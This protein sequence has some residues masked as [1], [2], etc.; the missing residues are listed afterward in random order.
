VRPGVTLLARCPHCDKPYVATDDQGPC[1]HCGQAADTPAPTSSTAP[2]ETSAVA[3]EGA[4]KDAPPGASRQEHPQE[5]SPRGAEARIAAPKGGLPPAPPRFVDGRPAW[6]QR[7]RS[8][9]FRFFGTLADACLRPMAFFTHLSRE[10]APR[11][12]PFAFAC[13]LI[14][15]IGQAVW[16][17]AMLPVLAALG[18]FATGRL[19]DE[20]R[21][22]A[23]EAAKDDALLQS[24]LSGIEMTEEAFRQVSQ[25]ELQLWTQLLLAPLVAFF[26]IHLL[27][28]LVHFSVQPWRHPEQEPVP[29]DVTYRFLIYSH[30]PMVLA[31]IPTVGGIASLFS[32]VLTTIA[33]SK[34]HRVRFF[35]LVGGV[36]F[37]VMML[38]W[39]WGGEVLPR[40]A[41]P[42]TSTLGIEATLS[43][44]L[45]PA[46]SAEATTTAAPGGDD[47]EEGDYPP[48]PA[49]D[50]EHSV[51]VFT[52]KG[53]LYSERFWNSSRGSF[54]IRHLVAAEPAAAGQ[55]PLVFEV[56]H[57]GAEPVER[58]IL[59]WSLP[60]GVSLLP[61]GR[62]APAGVFSESD[63][64]LTARWPQLDPGE[65][66]VLGV[67]VTASS[68]R[69]LLE[70]GAAV[71]LEPAGD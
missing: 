37:P 35:G 15:S 63:G 62:A 16:G 50:R 31:I 4:A 17:L 45:A 28:G 57:Q 32:F 19:S 27:A 40:I 55:W 53:W 21:E 30:A 52:Q 36:L 43:Q 13:L 39:L 46:P 33:I 44:Q 58:L 9:A 11:V 29:Y 18:R 51:E 42:L 67:T 56:L 24:L 38:S 61:G 41:E 5:P 25:L 47:L 54:R 65:T 70:R 3:A 2:S 8:L 1:P 7:E 60:E 59:E 12:T 49:A 48:M 14:G 20:Q 69:A 10:G 64:V 26:T 68:G 22:A 34:L 6:E 71:G 66:A 23:A